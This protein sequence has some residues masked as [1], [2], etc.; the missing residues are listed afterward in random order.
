MATTDLL[1]S[2]PP[3]AAK[4]R[5][6][7]AR[8]AQDAIDDKERA[9]KN[10]IKALQRAAEA[11]KDAQI[12]RDNEAR[13]RKKGIDDSVPLPEQYKILELTNGGE[14]EADRTAAEAKLI[15]ILEELTPVNPNKIIDNPW[16][17]THGMKDNGFYLLDMRNLNK[18]NLP[19]LPY[20][21]EAGLGPFTPLKI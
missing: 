19:D 8:N 13:A 1:Q 11:K 21:L 2:E 4:D 15:K 16:A 6:R 10:K 12:T 5:E 7:A 14:E 17:A 3:W 9:E 18:N 20:V